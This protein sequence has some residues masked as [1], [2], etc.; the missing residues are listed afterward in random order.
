VF[1]C[2]PKKDYCLQ[3]HE[4]ETKEVFDAMYTWIL[5]PQFCILVY[6]TTILVSNKSQN[7]YFPPSI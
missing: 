2:P 1:V 3:C 4:S 7:T 6:V 5:L